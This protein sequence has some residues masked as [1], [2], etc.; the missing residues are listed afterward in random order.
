MIPGMSLAERP[1]PPPDPHRG[2]TGSKARSLMMLQQSIAVKSA[3]CVPLA[4][5]VTLNKIL[6]H[7]CLI[8]PINK[9]GMIVLFVVRIR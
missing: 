4:N 8:F 6:P 3:G 1:G 9:I 2:H 5:C 7:V